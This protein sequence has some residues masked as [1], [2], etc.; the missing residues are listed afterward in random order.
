VIVTASAVS[1]NRKPLLSVPWSIS[2]NF[3]NCKEAG[4]IRNERCVKCRE[5]GMWDK[6]TRMRYSLSLN[7]FVTPFR[8]QLWNSN[9]RLSRFQMLNYFISWIADTASYICLRGWIWKYLITIEILSDPSKPLNISS[10]LTFCTMAGTNLI[11]ALLVVLIIILGTNLYLL[12]TCYF[13][14]KRWSSSLSSSR[15]RLPHRWLRRRSHHQHLPHSPWVGFSRLFSLINSDPL[16]ICTELFSGS[17]SRFLPR[18]CLLWS[19]ERDDERRAGTCVG[20]L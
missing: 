17:Y 6:V 7:L 20:G 10:A 9:V 12:F 8:H 5:G 14:S 19:S 3:V 18:I 13:N 11:F 2:T 4:K 16:L 15:R 1:S